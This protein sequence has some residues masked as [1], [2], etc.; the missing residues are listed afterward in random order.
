LWAEFDVDSS[1]TATVT[2][3]NFWNGGY[4]AATT[5]PG[6]TGT[7]KNQYEGERQLKIMIKLAELYTE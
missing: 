3:D 5:T 4:T 1:S 6:Y 7:L 2:A